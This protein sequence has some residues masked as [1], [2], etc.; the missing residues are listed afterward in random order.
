MSASERP[1]TVAACPSRDELTA[2]LE[3][4]LPVAALERVADHLF[5]CPP[6]EAAL[7]TVREA[8][9]LVSELRHCRG[10]ST[11]V[12]DPLVERIEAR[13]RRIG[14]ESAVKAP[15]PAASDTP[16][17]AAEAFPKTFGKFRLLAKL[18]QGGM[19]VV[20]KAQEVWSDLV[21]ALKVVRAG[22]HAAP[23]EL[24]RFQVEA[25]AVARL[26]HPNV[27]QI[28]D[29]GTQDEMPYFTMELLE[30]G[31]LAQRLKERP[32]SAHEAAGLVQSLAGAVHAAHQK[33]IVHRD[34]KPAN[35]LLTADGTPKI[36]DFGLA[37]LLDAELVA[38]QSNVAMGTPAYMA[39][40]QAR[41]S[42]KAVGPAADIYALGAI[43]YELLCGRPP[44]QGDGRFDILD[45]VRTRSPAP[46]SRWRAGI[47]PVL[48]AVCLKCL[49]KVPADRYDSAAAFAA[50]LGR[51]LRGESTAVRPLRWPAR[52]VRFVR[53]H[54]WV[55]LLVLLTATAG[56]LAPFFAAAP[57]PPPGPAPDTAVVDSTDNTLQQL[58][59]GQPVTL[60]GAT[61]RPTWH[62]VRL[63]GKAVATFGGD[64]DV[65]A[66]TSPTVA[67]IEL[68]PRVP[69][70]RYRFT[71]EV[72]HQSS[73]D[74]GA[75][76]VYFGH[77]TRP[78]PQGDMHYFLELSFADR[79]TAAVASWPL[80]L[81]LRRYRAPQLGSGQINDALR[82]PLSAA[83]EP[84]P[85]V[86]ERLWRAVTAVVTPETVR[87]LQGNREVGSLSR[88]V[89]TQ[90]ARAWLSGLKDNGAPGKSFT[91]RG[92]LGLYVYRGTVL[93]RSV[94]VTPTATRP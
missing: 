71:A 51:W 42:S 26:K 85:G 13:A 21:V 15:G 4:R 47:D 70:D 28:Y 59:A 82:T 78:S 39:P 73:D 24:A 57:E 54:R 89:L 38:T 34:L 17:R 67:L 58:G 6:C 80:T 37:K 30:G 14:Q 81:R 44:F 20:Y 9:T 25:R 33:E 2:Y 40:E 66:V 46:P 1:S 87:V 76:G 69:L 77:A 91:P 43:L 23:E 75:V 18:G 11:I 27:V 31:S 3:G 61:G 52:A 94:T 5:R 93:F 74:D 16:P 72:L 84:A 48:D 65:F 62:R 63:G 90:L 7:L 55:A 45:Q 79:K 12:E 68:L 86:G 29:P 56:G 36:A 50:D 35:V 49:E 92:G 19:G 22:A 60:I 41:G 10:G 8:D 88:P 53:R 32:Y 83:L 64:K